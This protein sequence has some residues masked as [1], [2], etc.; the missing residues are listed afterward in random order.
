VASLS[1]CAGA[2][3]QTAQVLARLADLKHEIVLVGGQAVNFWANYYEKRVPELAD[4][5]P[6]TSSMSARPAP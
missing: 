6:Y 1:E 2:S 3:Q 5:A 4:G